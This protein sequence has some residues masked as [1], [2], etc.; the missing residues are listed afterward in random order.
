MYYFCNFCR[1]VYY[2]VRERLFCELWKKKEGK[3][4]MEDVVLA[5]ICVFKVLLR[6]ET[7]AVFGHLLWTLCSHCTL[8]ELE[9]FVDSLSLSC[10][11]CSAHGTTKT[12]K[13]RC[14]GIMWWAEHET[15][16]TYTFTWNAVYTHS[17][18]KQQNNEW[19]KGCACRSSSL[20]FTL[21][22]AVPHTGY[23]ILWNTQVM[24]SSFIC[25]FNCKINKEKNI[26]GRKL[27]I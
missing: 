26:I 13:H 24:P 1:N 15:T 10:T 4:E 18:I 2:S 21:K 17:A 19:N 20:L 23:D 27:C 9:K 5:E 14:I 12:G 11:I 16:V 22:P 8:Y 25:W 6:A 7:G 3:K